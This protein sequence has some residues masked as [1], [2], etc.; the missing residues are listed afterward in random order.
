MR[1]GNTAWFRGCQMFL[2]GVPPHFLALI[3]KCGEFSVLNMAKN[4]LLFFI[5]QAIIIEL[6]YHIHYFFFIIFLSFT[7]TICY[8][9]V[10]CEKFH[11]EKC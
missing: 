2:F 10:E 11:F 1:I 4:L 7:A 9:L 8:L 6:Q 5:S 3:L